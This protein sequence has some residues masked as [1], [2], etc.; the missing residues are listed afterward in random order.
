MIKIVTAVNRK[1]ILDFI[2]F[3]LKYCSEFI[4]H[5]KNLI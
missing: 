5:L 3:F 4:D 2:P 1:Y